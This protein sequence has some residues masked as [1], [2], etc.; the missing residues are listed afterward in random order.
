MFPLPG[1]LFS[2]TQAGLAPA[3]H[4]GTTAV[5]LAALL[6]AVSVTQQTHG[7]GTATAAQGSHPKV[8]TSQLYQPKVLGVKVQ[9]G[10]VRAWAWLNSVSS[11]HVPQADA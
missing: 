4:L 7:V 11:G 6:S 1:T 2:G 8:G 9:G 10:E 5:A 3:L